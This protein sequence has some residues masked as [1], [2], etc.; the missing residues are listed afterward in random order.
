MSTFDGGRQVSDGGASLLGIADRTLDLTSPIAA[1]FPD[2]RSPQRVR[3]P[4]VALI[5]QRVFASP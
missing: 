3:H 5:R 2:H 4:M 1:C